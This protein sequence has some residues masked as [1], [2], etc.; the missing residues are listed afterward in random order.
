MVIF[1]TEAAS[2]SPINT[3]SAIGCPLFAPGMALAM[4]RTPISDTAAT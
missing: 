1:A 3:A 2:D 4:T